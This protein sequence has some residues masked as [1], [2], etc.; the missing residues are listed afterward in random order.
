MKK[1][2][3]LVNNLATGPRATEGGITNPDTLATLLTL[4]LGKSLIRSKLTSA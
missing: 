1:Y 3:C 4:R 2:I